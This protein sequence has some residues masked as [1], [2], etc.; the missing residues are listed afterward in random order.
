M[1]PEQEGNRSVAVEAVLAVKTLM[2]RCSTA[3]RGGQVQ[4]S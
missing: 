4:R 3:P 2:R 1:T